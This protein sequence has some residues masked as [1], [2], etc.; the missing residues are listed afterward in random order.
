M[1]PLSTILYSHRRC[2]PENERGARWKFTMCDEQRGVPLARDGRRTTRVRH[3]GVY[4]IASWELFA[5]AF[6]RRV[7]E[8]GGRSRAA[9][10]ANQKAG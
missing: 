5:G 4:K 1:Y 7:A 3:A 10:A 9:S 2:A 8:M 6:I